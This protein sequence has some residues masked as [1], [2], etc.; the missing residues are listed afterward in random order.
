MKSKKAKV[1]WVIILVVVLGS[2][3]GYF[4][5]SSSPATNYSW[6]LLSKN[7]HFKMDIS[8]KSQKEISEIVETVANTGYLS[9]LGK[10]GHLDRLG[11]I[12]DKEVETLDFWGYIFSQPKLANDM[13]KIQGESMKYN[14]FVQNSGKGFLKAYHQNKCFLEQVESFAKYLKINPKKTVELMKECL[15]KGESDKNAF[16]PFI[17]YLIEEKSKA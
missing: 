9:L 17:D 5:L 2:V 15:K 16:K 1:L 10:K 12:V 7:C 8:D 11:D 6:N 3:G 14:N 4:F 13:K